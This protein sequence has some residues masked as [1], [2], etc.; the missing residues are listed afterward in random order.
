[1]PQSYW[2]HKDCGGQLYIGDNANLYCVRCQA[3]KHIAYWEN[4]CTH[5]ND[6]G[7]DGVVTLLDNPVLPLASVISVFGQMT[8]TTGVSWLQRSLKNLDKDVND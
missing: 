4:G 8:T 1:M 3:E 7:L 5:T 6:T 2:Q